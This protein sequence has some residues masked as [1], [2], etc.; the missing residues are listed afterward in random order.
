MNLLFFG[1]LSGV[2]FGEMIS[3]FLGYLDSRRNA[4]DFEEW[5]K[6]YGNSHDKLRR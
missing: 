1:F 4:R 6:R 2:I 3:L 5:R